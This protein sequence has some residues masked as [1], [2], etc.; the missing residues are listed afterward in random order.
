MRRSLESDDTGKM[1]SHSGALLS[2]EPNEGDNQNLSTALQVL[3]LSMTRK[4]M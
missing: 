4:V 3:A 1:E 2:T